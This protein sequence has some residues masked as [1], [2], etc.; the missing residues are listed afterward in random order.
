[1][2]EYI[3]KVLGSILYLQIRWGKIPTKHT[4]PTFLKLL[5]PIVGYTEM[6]RPI[7]C[8]IMRV[9]SE[10]LGKEEEWV[11]KSVADGY[12]HLKPVS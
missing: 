4:Y 3:S 6:D 1:M 7:V 10:F 5:L 8:I 2:V 11:I 12:F 9:F